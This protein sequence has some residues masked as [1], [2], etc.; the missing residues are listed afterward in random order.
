MSMTAARPLSP[1]TARI[2][3]LND[4]LRRHG[5]GGRT[6]LTRGLSS[7]PTDDLSAVLWAVT[8][9]DAFTDDMDPY[10]E[11]DFGSFEIHGYRIFFKIDGGDVALVGDNNAVGS[12][13][14]MT[15]M[16]AEE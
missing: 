4:T 13:R 3:A 6:L 11:H 9:F 5:M 8:K 2:R 12:G 14:V 15:I 16:L 10:G 1:T 7:L